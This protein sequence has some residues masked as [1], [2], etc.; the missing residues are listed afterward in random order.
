MQHVQ[1]Q[2]NVAGQAFSTTQPV[3]LQQATEVGALLN[4]AVSRC[5]NS[6]ATLVLAAAVVQPQKD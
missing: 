1:K 6:P 2:H 4:E 5:P 3:H